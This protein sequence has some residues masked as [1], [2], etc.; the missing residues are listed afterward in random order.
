MASGLCPKQACSG[1]EDDSKCLCGQLSFAICHAIP[2]SMY[3][4]KGCQSGPK[5]TML[6]LPTAFLPAC[7]YYLM[8]SSTQSPQSPFPLPLIP[9]PNC[10]SPSCPFL[11]LCA[12]REPSRQ[13]CASSGCQSRDADAH[14]AQSLMVLHQVAA[15]SPPYLQQMSSACA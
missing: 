2:P 15:A 10:S 4:G 9:C 3:P 5:S 1:H 13:Q 6:T 11:R 14:Q 8:A 12:A 7:L